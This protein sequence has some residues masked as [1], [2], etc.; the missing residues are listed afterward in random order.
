MSKAAKQSIFILIFLVLLCLGFAGFFWFQTQNLEENL[1]TRSD[2]LR[3]AEDRIKISMNDAKKLN[4]Q[5]Q[6]VVE[7]KSNLQSKVESTEKKIKDLLNQVTEASDEKDKWKRRVENIRSE[8]D[9]LMNKVKELTMEMKALE[10]APSVA[11]V[12]R[13]PSELDIVSPQRVISK[14]VIVT[15]P[16]SDDN[17]E[18]WAAILKEKASLEV[19]ITKMRDELSNS[20]IEI[21]EFKQKNADLQL[22]LDMI[23][24]ENEDINR[25]IQYKEDLIN[26]LSL[27]L[28]RTKNDKK[29]VNDRAEKLSSENLDL[30]KQMKQLVNT[31]SSL[32]KSIVRISQDKQKVERSLQ[33]TESL[34]QGKI[35]E[36]WEI[37]ESL[38]RTFKSSHLRAPSS[39]DIELPPIVVS[40]EGPAVAHGPGSAPGFNGRVVSINSENNFIIVDIGENSGINLGDNLS[41]YRN[42]KYIARLEVIQVRKD[43][44]AADIKDQWA[45]VEVGDVVR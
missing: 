9:D 22:E 5:L 6:K 32:E 25:E 14:P 33:E 24:Q 10:R 7:D 26:N 20:A 38:D 40:T 15:T 27:E 34:I 12:S 4:A 3:Q 18:H 23:N 30:R 44:S 11:A 8:R 2:E 45:R 17:E 37:K 13:T 39:S 35:D 42:S 1:A 43:I 29:F 41:V 28:A 21:V 16:V 36:I 31:K 19:Q